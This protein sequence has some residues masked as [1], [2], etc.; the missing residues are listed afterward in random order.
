M[1]GGSLRIGPRYFH[2]LLGLSGGPRHGYALMRELAE[3]TGGRVELGP[4]SLYYSLGRLEDA[5]LIE[6]VEGVGDSDEPHED[7][8][9]YY[10]LTDA[11]RERLDEESRILEGLLDHAKA[12]GFGGPG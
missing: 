11:G 2:L 9:R 12:M 4:S 10:A 1:P 3:R 8:R 7:Q 6:A 5:G